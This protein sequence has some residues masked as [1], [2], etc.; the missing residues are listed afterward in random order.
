MRSR[1]ETALIQR[2]YNVIFRID[3]D[4]P[5]DALFGFI[6]GD[7]D[8]CKLFFSLIFHHQV[9]SI[10]I[11]LQLDIAEDQIRLLFLHVGVDLFH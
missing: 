11:I 7:K 6:R 5:I 10:T 2:F 8:Q 9:N 4:S 3:S 1:V